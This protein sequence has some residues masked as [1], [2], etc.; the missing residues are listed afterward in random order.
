MFYKFD[1]Q[2]FISSFFVLFAIID[3]IGT[4]PIIISLKKRGKKLNPLKAA[5]LSF[6]MF[7]IFLYVGEAFL[8]LFNV[9]ISSFAVAGSLII[10]IMALEMVLDIH[11]FKDTEDSPKDSGK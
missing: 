10:F 1:F 9:D 5:L 11:I 3:I 6:A 4:M 8:K 2:Q 7:M